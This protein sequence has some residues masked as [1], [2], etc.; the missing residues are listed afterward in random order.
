M[1][2][3]K[4]IVFSAPDLTLLFNPY[5]RTR[6]SRSS[7]LSLSVTLGYNPFRLPPRYPVAM[8][9]KPITVTLLSLGQAGPGA[10]LP[11]VIPAEQWP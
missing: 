7:N 10:A 5:S 9:P 8:H 4:R 2:S 1:V 3:Q 6:I 11:V